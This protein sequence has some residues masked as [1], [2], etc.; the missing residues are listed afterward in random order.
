M[1]YLI[2]LILI[3]LI[4]CSGSGKVETDD[5]LIRDEVRNYLF[6]DDSI[7]VAAQITDTILVEELNGMLAT[8]EDNLMKIQLDIDTLG[9]MI[10]DIAYDPLTANEEVVEGKY[11]TTEKGDSKEVLL[12]K[13]RLKMAELKA[14]KLSFQ[15]SKRVMLHLRRKQLNSIAGY[16]VQATYI[17]NG[18]NI[19]LGFLMTPDFN[20]VD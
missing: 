18:E 8:I 19:E 5:E 2:P 4:S 12:L 16:E 3:F 13:Y 1:K 20:I 6:L 17:V 15:Q 7:K 9:L 11:L 10:D 14:K